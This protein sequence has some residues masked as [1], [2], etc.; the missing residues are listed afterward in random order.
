[1]EGFQLASLNKVMLSNKIF[2]HD[3]FTYSNSIFGDQD[4]FPYQSLV[5]SRS[6][7]FSAKLQKYDLCASVCTSMGLRLLS[8]IL[9]TLLLAKQNLTLRFIT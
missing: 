8:S 3:F 6:K 9:K 1:M 5:I 2:Y 7:V 4:G